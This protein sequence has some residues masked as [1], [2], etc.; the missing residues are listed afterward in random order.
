MTIEIK[1]GIHT[2]CLFTFQHSKGDILGAIQKDK[3]GWF[4]KVRERIYV[5]HLVFDKKKWMITRIKK[6]ESSKDFIE[7]IIT[8]FQSTARKFN[9]KLEIIE[10][11]S[12]T[13]TD[14]ASNRLMK[15]HSRRINGN[16][17]S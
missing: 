4:S 14:E 15:L 17:R 10:I 8:L 1:P 9:T 3:R 11:K 12:E 7:K 16:K 2:H 13:L 6:K 5:D